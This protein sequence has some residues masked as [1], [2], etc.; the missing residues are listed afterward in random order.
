M[1]PNLI[2]RAIALYPY[3]SYSPQL[4]ACVLLVL[5]LWLLSW[6]FISIGVA[7][8]IY[9]LWGFAYKRQQQDVRLKPVE[10]YDAK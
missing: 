7:S 8:L 9:Q 5:G 4:T 10:T 6:T 1:G 2:Q 3:V